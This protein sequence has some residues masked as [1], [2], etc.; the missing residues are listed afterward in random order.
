MFVFT[1]V[2]ANMTT[3]L[4]PP[5]FMFMAGPLQQS[6]VH[7]PPIMTPLVIAHDRPPHVHVHDHACVHMSCWPATPLPSPVLRATCQV[8]D[9]P[10]SWHALTDGLALILALTLHWP[11]TPMHMSGVHNT[12]HSW[13]LAFAFGV[14]CICVHGPS[15]LWL[16]VCV[17]V[18]GLAFMFAFAVPCVCIHDQ[19]LA[20]VVFTPAPSLALTCVG[21]I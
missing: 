6:H 17:C 3:S 14:L 20:F 9:W 5:L 16:C 8:C 4:P 2:F 19:P 7:D 12:L 11:S 18:C 10:S 1:A 21:Y 13:S 15:H